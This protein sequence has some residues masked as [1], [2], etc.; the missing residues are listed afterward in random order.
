MAAPKSHVKNGGKAWDTVKPLHKWFKDLSRVLLVDD[1]S[2][3][4]LSVA[5][6]YCMHAHEPACK[7][8]SKLI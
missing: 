3:K 8:A 2:Y 5:L 7:N 6:A 1:D 4:V